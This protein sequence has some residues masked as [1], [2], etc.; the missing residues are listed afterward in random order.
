MARIARFAVTAEIVTDIAS[1]RAIDDILASVARRSA[2][3]LEVWE[4]DVYEY[5]PEA[6]TVTCLATWARGSAGEG[7]WLGTAMAVADQPAFRCALSERRMVACHLDDANLA[8]LDRVRM[9]S[10]GERSALIVPLTVRGEA[11]GC[12]A[13]IE[14]RHTRVFSARDRQLAATLAALAAMAIDNARLYADVRHMAITDGLTGLYNHRY[15][16]ERL[17]QEVA[18]AQRYGLPVSLLM[19]D[20]DAFKDC[21]DRYG[22]RFGDA[23]LCRLGELL[24]AETRQQVDLLARYGGEEFAI[25]MPSTG[26]H[27][28]AG[29]PGRLLRGGAEP[30]AREPGA[31]E[32]VS[33]AAGDEDAADA[34]SVAERIRRRVASERFAADVEPPVVTI[35]V[36]VA[37][38]SREIATAAQ[39]VECADAALYAA[40]Q[41][42]KNRVEAAGA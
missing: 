36:G 23:V 38:L 24:I 22:H 30:H 13:L 32:A 26:G 42:G 20:L 19:L 3:A 1:S 18:R 11:L 35:S 37:V 25:I 34:R 33:L 29:A 14:S 40:K 39:L 10:W 5:T 27:D 9:E 17:T 8:A 21:N 2:Q 16:Y 15:F 12:L 31:P 28:A 6:G 7:G 41:R 4:C